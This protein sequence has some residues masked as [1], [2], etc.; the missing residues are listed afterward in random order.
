M[1]HDFTKIQKKFGIREFPHAMFYEFD[2]ALRFEL[3]GN[4]I[5]VNRPLRRFI[6]AFERARTISQVLF[7]QSAEVCIL[8]ASYGTVQLD[9]KRLKPF[10]LCGLSRSKFDYLGKTPQVDEVPIAE[11]DSDLFRHWDMALL[12]D[13]QM[14]AEIIWLCIAP[15]LGIRPST[16]GL[17]VYLVDVENGLALHVYDDRGMDV[18]SVEKTPLMSI[19]AEYH[20]WLLDSDL[21]QM[22]ETF[23]NKQ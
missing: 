14:M 9:K 10:K 11:F 23:S 6:Q 16:R 19:F 20:N 12:K 21:A 22:T 2:H 7:S 8:V 5:G 17:S 1:K 4:G 15:E 18:V 13:K 3:G